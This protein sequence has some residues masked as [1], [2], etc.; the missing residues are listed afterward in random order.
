MLIGT[1]S[2]SATTETTTPIF[3][4]SLRFIA[5]LYGTSIPHCVTHKTDFRKEYENQHG[6]IKRKNPEKSA[7]NILLFVSFFRIICLKLFIGEG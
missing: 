6:V 4:S 7:E 5:C 3:L 2:T 1:Y